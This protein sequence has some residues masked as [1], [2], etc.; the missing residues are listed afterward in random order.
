M[1]SL[2][3][4]SSFEDTIFNNSHTVVLLI[5]PETGKIL[6]A[7]P[8]ALVFYGLGH[9]QITS[10]NISDINTLPA[11]QIQAAMQSART[12]ERTSFE[13]QHRV[14]GGLVREVEI[15]S[16]PVELGGKTFLFSVVVDI[17]ERRQVERQ[18][19]ELRDGLQEQVTQ[20][21]SE[22]V[23]IN[24]KLRQEIEERRLAER[25]LL[26]A[27]SE[28]HRFREA[29]DHHDAY[30]YMKG[31]DFRYLY[32]NRP[33]LELFG[34]SAAELV[35]SYD[36]RFF[37]PQDAK[38]LR[39]VDQRVLAGERIAE[40][41]DIVNIKG[42]RRVYWMVK[43]PIYE[44]EACRTVWGLCGINTDITDR[45][46]A[47]ESQLRTER[48][49]QQAHT[50]LQELTAHMHNALDNERRSI[51]RDVHDELGT[52]LTT[53][54]FDLAWMKRNYPPVHR[55]IAERIESMETI[56]HQA[57]GAVH[58]IVSDLRP[59]L[60]DDDD[61]LAT[62]EWHAKEFEN[63]TGIVCT[64]HLDAEQGATIKKYST[65]LFRI[66]QESMTNIARHA[67]A[68]MVDISLLVDRGRT[69]LQ[70]SDDGRGISD[71]ELSAFDSF[72]IQGMKERV[73]LNGG[74]IV[75]TG[76]PGKG[77]TVRVIIP[78]GSEDIQ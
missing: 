1:D 76:M 43:T 70:V 6:D 57:M 73:R 2:L 33:T 62:I 75:I 24:N 14:A 74:E 53:L 55:A 34:C 20:R 68:S 35:G 27:L 16:G 71:R 37:P 18:L 61:L 7:N 50:V 8:A 60:I 65:G 26:R 12:R 28:V 22:L 15:R 66:F 41:L 67:K 72:G 64:L 58:R 36:S 40:E 78:N 4:R 77:T 30:V 11:D 63:R 51:A 45:K 49:L 39:G 9:D 25:N 32:G 5:E 10:L 46:L 47:E 17:G 23:I 44:D 3:P 69:V 13:F 21:T 42:E 59:V 56:I 31:R 48:E 19:V 54:K 29:M 38:R 52:A